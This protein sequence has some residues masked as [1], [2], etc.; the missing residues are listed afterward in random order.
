MCGDMGYTWGI[1]DGGAGVPW[2]VETV[3]DQ[4][5][6]FCRLAESGGVPF[7]VLCRRFGISRKTGYKWLKRY[8]ADGESALE[9]RSRR[10]LSSPARTSVEMERLVCEVRRAHPWGGRKIRGFLLRQGHRGVPAASTITTILRRHGLITEAAPRR[11]YQRF[12]RAEPNDL[13]QMDFKG[14]FPL[15]DGQRVH[16]LGVLDDHSR[17]NLCLAA[18]LNQR[19]GTVKDRLTSTFG[20]YGLPWAMLMDNGSPWGDAQHPWTPLTVWMI[21]LGI[22]VIH[23]APYHPQTAGKQ[24]RHNGTVELEVISTRAR[25]ETLTEYQEALDQ[26]RPIYN[27]HRPHESLGETIVPADRYQPSPRSFPD[28]IDPPRYPD[29]W[30]T[31]IVDTN[32]RISFRGTIYKAGR[33]FRRRTIALAPQ[34]DGTWIIH[35]R[36]Q[37]I[38]T[39]DP[40]THVPEHP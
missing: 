19:T 37:P 26:W 1:V 2:K 3:A 33:A 25:W 40:V 24:E 7:V 32:A 23:S 4:R 14:W 12:E 36:H 8:R 5:L 9:D 6:E 31:R 21:D 13:W 28:H 35:Y 20:Q 11:A 39:I 30:P 27:H 18:C 29:H 10:P 16:T 15:L 22:E 34:T 38:R 17:Y